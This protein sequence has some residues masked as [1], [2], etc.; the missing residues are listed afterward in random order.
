MEEGETGV[1]E[2]EGEAREL[3]EG[4]EEGEA[5]ELGEGIRMVSLVFLSGNAMAL[6]LAH[7]WTRLIHVWR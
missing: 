7:S 1:G 3:G 2:E 5:G 6:I 4:E